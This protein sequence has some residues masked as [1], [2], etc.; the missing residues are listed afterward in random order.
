MKS[1]RL[2][3]PMISAAIT[4]LL[5]GGTETQASELPREEVRRL[6]WKQT[7]PGDVEGWNARQQKLQSRVDIKP[8]LFALV[9]EAYDKEDWERLGPPLLALRL[10][11]DLSPEE[12]SRLV[13]P[14]TEN[15]ERTGPLDM[16]TKAF[17]CGALPV[18]KHYPS[19]E[20]EKLVLSYLARDDTLIQENAIN[21]LAE[22]GTGQSLPA[23]KELSEKLRPAPG[24]KN[25]YYEAA[26][27]AVAQI[28]ARIKAVSLK[29]AEVYEP[30]VAGGV[31][32]SVEVSETTDARPE[33]KNAIVWWVLVVL[34]VAATGLLWLL[35]KKRK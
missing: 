20:H 22:I 24:N 12:L 28:E 2:A 8:D 21:T 23:L 33:S 9:D 3:N 17:V 19:A 30:R 14:L 34:I 5:I 26:V 32:E 18:L 11:S 16:M 1:N 29:P 6:V 13:D 25:R 35:V 15:Q 7:N 31:A 27:D 10:R 4:L